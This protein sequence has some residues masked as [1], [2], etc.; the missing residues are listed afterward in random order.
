MTGKPTGYQFG[1]ATQLDVFC[2]V[3]KRLGPYPHQKLN[4]EDRPRKKDGT[5]QRKLG[6]PDCGIVFRG[7]RATIRKGLPLCGT[8]KPERCT[9]YGVAFELWCD[10][11][12]G[13][14]D[15]FTEDCP[16][17]EGATQPAP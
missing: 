1:A 13:Y 10:D 9:R 3:V 2:A 5:R 11:C 6:C 7:A 8:T 17:V 12:E 14:G 16:G 4:P 15:H